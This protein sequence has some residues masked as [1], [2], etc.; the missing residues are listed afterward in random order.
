[1]VAQVCNLQYGDFIHSFGDV[2]LYNNHIDQA[3]LQLTRTPY[4][5]PIIRIN[6]EISNI[7]D[8]TFEDFTLENY[9]H[10]SPIKATVAI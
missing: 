3:N 2:H 7:F 10:H 5:L 6:P 9:Q 8:F 1:M 4:P